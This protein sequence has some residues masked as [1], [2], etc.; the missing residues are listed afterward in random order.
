MWIQAGAEVL[1]IGSSTGG[2]FFV[3]EL[4]LLA[5]IAAEQ[6]HADAA[7]GYVESR[8]PQPV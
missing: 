4:P 8:E 7:V 5:D 2:T 3:I 1:E 6:S